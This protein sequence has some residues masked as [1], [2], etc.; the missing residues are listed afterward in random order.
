MANIRFDPN[1]IPDTPTLI[2]AKKSTQKLGAINA[3]GIVVKDNFQNP[4]EITFTVYEESC[5][6]YKD[7][8][9]FKFV[10]CKEWDKWFEITNVEVEETDSKKKNVICTE[11]CQAELSQIKLFNIEINTDDD[12]KREDYV[13]PTVLY[14]P[15]KPEESL[16]HRITQKAVNF[17][18]LHVDSTIAN[19]Q[20]TF[21]FDDETIYDAF[22]KIAEEIDC[23]F[24]FDSSTDNNG[25]IVRGIS[26]YDMQDNCTNPDCLNRGYFEN[27]VCPKCGSTS[28]YE[29][30]G[31]DT[32]VFVTADE[33][34]ENIKLAADTDSVKNCFKLEAGDEF[35]TATIRNC[36]PNGTDYIW[37]ITD[38]MT[39]EM[40]AEL[41]D[42]LERYNILYNEY[43]TEIDYIRGVSW[44]T[45][46]N[47][48]IRKYDDYNPKLK[49]IDSII[50]YPSLI[51][52][53]Y[54][55]VDF[56][57]YVKTSMMPT[58]DI[59][60]PTAE[61]EL[62]V[63]E[64]LTTISSDDIDNI[65]LTTAE[66]IIIS[67]AKYF[68]DPR[69]KVELF[70]DSLSPKDEATNT[71]SWYGKFRIIDYS[72]DTN[73]AESISSHRIVIN[74]NYENFLKYKVFGNIN[75][76][77]VNEPGIVDMFKYNSNP[78]DPVTSPFEMND[79]TFKS[80]IKKYS[81]D[82]LSNMQ[83][84]VQT[85]IDVM[86]EQDITNQGEHEAYVYNLW[87][88]LYVPWKHRLNW[89]EKEMKTKE[90][91]LYYISDFISDCE[92]H[93][94]VTHDT[95]DFQNFLGET[96]WK[97]FVLFKREQKYS[98]DNYI[99]DGLNNS[100]VIE[101]A[102]EF[103][104]AAKK[105]LYKAA[106]LQ[107]TIN[108]TLRNLLVIDKFQ[109]I[110]DRFKVGNWIRIKADNNIYRLRLLSYE[111]DYDNLEN[112]SVD[113]SDVIKTIDGETDQQS[114]MD[115]MMS[116]SSSYNYT[117]YQAEKGLKSKD[118][119]DNWNSNGI[120]VANVQIVNTANNQSQTWDENGMLFRK[121]DPREYVLPNTTTPV[122]M[123][124]DPRQ[125]KIINSTISFTQ[126]NWASSSTAVGLFR[127][128]DPEIGEEVMKYGINAES[129]VGKLI[130]GN[131]LKIFNNDGSLV[132]DEEGLVISDKDKKNIVY[133]TPKKPDLFKIVSIKTVG[134][135]GQE[136]EIE[137]VMSFNNDGQLSLTGNVTAKN[138]SFSDDS[139]K[140]KYLKVDQ[141]GNVIPI[142]TISA[143][144]VKIGSLS[145]DANFNIPLV[146]GTGDDKMLGCDSSN[147]ITYNPSTNVLAINNGNG[148]VKANLEGNA[149][150]ATTAT[151]AGS[152]NTANS[153]NNATNVSI[154]SEYNDN[155][156]KV[157]FANASSG[158][159]VGLKYD[160]DSF[161][162]NPYT[163]TL[164][165]ANVN[166][167]STSSASADVSTKSE[168]TRLSDN[169]SYPLVMVGNRNPY[170]SS[171]ATTNELLSY[172]YYNSTYGVT[173]N[174]YSGTLIVD[175]GNGN[176]N[177]KASS[178]ISAD[179]ATV[180][181]K[182]DA[183]KF[184]NYSSSYDYSIPLFYDS[185]GEY[186][187][188]GKDS[189]DSIKYNPS[190]KTLSIDSGNGVIDA[191]ATSADSADSADSAMTA[192]K[193]KVDSLGNNNAYPLALVAMPTDSNS[194]M[195]KNANTTYN[196]LTGTLT[197][198]SGNGTIDG[199]ATSASNAD[200]ATNAT[201]ADYVDFDLFS[202]STY[203][204]PLYYNSTSEYKKLGKDS[205]D[206]IKYNPSTKT[207][208]ITNGY[209]DAVA[210]SARSADNATYASK[211]VDYTSTSNSVEIGY[212]GGSV[213]AQ[214]ASYVAVYTNGAHIK[215][216]SF[217]ELA[218]K[219]ADQNIRPIVYSTSAPSSTLATGTVWLQYEE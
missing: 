187:Q 3:H 44:T 14:N 53:Y 161:A 29:R 94:N 108:T 213:T 136:T 120:N 92:D 175:G 102:S 95:L 150:T 208:T 197:I 119:L 17:K 18:I 46:Y 165:V 96:L 164:T 206:N 200:N 75:Q 203:S 184:G 122:Y 19:I 87:Y 115:K 63:M 80:E 23:V 211:V 140:E 76:N 128:I 171:S 58:V 181:Q 64:G 22:Q 93:I 4:C 105:E 192:N 173:Y 33:L 159:Y 180:S 178:A 174:P 81:L 212:M 45:D 27:G 133:I 113:F 137:N 112:L 67:W 24:I 39:A 154:S 55:S 78:L 179:S 52:A 111:I 163:N 104:T 195:G 190:T 7:I 210:T 170:S 129:V 186:K 130:L 207:L 50:G 217:A 168:I 65:S 71:Y 201:Y 8:K 82:E 9:D 106:E 209:V 156:Y 40:S 32:G 193:V 51:E 188:L 134:E 218:T 109:P 166:G 73:K 202:S 43:Q 199:K 141:N 21:K 70:N 36:N 38:D 16:L 214:N 118:V 48:L 216:M 61:H 204:I 35:M 191:K 177:G 117:Q 1:G 158:G 15:N 5:E 79:E 155:S 152:A 47:I 30:Y 153:A 125:M 176:I 148:T 142:N 10:W 97:E 114:V 89:I 99:S 169:N 145:L 194:S 13:N 162:Y 132:F 146:Y 149:D 66:N 172:P 131:E 182:S 85:C 90:D 86:V 198:N 25:N 160:T 100:E 143:S 167:K 62:S 12:I 215:D 183:V 2:L 49:T 54:E 37:Y 219:L 31:E 157:T 74:G 135:E 69:Y 126:D 60:Q 151:T 6:L 83:K 57:H 28:I 98:N 110:V 127:Y 205:G 196:P 138:L 147:D 72:D 56:Y 103:L 91:D 88:C 124:Y 20:R 121:Y 189:G 26:V 68:V 185:S 139:Y 42:R 101:K 144:Y 11:V 107:H 59:S 41:Q 84:I 116:M 123:E 34:G 77:K